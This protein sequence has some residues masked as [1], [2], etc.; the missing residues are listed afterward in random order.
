M[1]EEM[2]VWELR[3][4]ELRDQLEARMT[5]GMMLM[6]EYQKPPEC[7]LLFGSEEPNNVGKSER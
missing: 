7:W 1:E 6:L 4:A 3:K 5:Q 2:K